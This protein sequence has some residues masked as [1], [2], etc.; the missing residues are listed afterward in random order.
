MQKQKFYIIGHNPNTFSEA[1]KFL[2]AG[3]N[4]LEPDLHYVDG[5]IYVIHSWPPVSTTP[6]LPPVMPPLLSEYLEKLAAYISDPKGDKVNLAWILFDT[7]TPNFDVNLIFDNFRKYFS[8]K[9]DKCAGVAISVTCASNDDVNFVTA[10]QQNVIN[11]GVGIDEWGDPEAVRTAFEHRDQRQTTFANGTATFWVNDTVFQSISHAKYMQQ[12]ETNRFKLIYVWVLARKSSM[13]AFLGIHVDGIIV[14]I[15]TVKTLRKILEEKEFASQYELAQNGYNPFAAT[16]RPGY[17]VLA[18]T[19]NKHMAGS[20]AI[21][22]FTLKGEQGTLTTKVDADYGGVFEAD[23]ECPFT[24]E[25]EAIGKII[26]LTI[27]ALDSDISSD[28]LPEWIVIKSY[29]LP[30]PVTFK[31]GPGEWVRHGYPITKYA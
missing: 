17:G 21:F 27:E 28:W 16:P 4:A 5:K 20:D 22:L 9:S 6:S 30:V 10:Y 15:S 1:K 31:F 13:R 25:G 24:F 3:A 8:S 11:G 29:A 19:R 23:T 12:V 7:K 2:K 14:N 18:R 26:S